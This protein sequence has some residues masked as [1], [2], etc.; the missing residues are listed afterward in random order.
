VNTDHTENLCLIKL[1]KAKGN[2]TDLHSM[3]ANFPI[4]YFV[5]YIM[6]D[7]RHGLD[8][9]GSWTDKRNVVLNREIYIG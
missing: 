2:V 9:S 7:V 6:W 8:L 1:K 4:K 3:F 5:I